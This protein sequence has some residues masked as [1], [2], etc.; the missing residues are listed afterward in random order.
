MMKKRENER[1]TEEIKGKYSLKWNKNAFRIHN[2]V[3]FSFFLY[4]LFAKA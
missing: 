4:I 3:K 2:F 1:K